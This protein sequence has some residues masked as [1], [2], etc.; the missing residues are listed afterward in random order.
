MVDVGGGVGST[1]LIIARAVPH[2]KVVVQ[3]RPA[4]L[5]DAELVRKYIFVN[6]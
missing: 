4:V 1:S 6:T 3:D 2:I 5:S